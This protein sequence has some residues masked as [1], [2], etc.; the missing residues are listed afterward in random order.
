M[1][2]TRSLLVSLLITVCVS[3]LAFGLAI[4]AS[5]RRQPERAWLIAHLQLGV[6]L[7]AGIL[8]WDFPPALAMIALQVS[9]LAFVALII[10]AACLVLD[11]RQERRQLAIIAAL[12]VSSLA[13]AGFIGI[14]FT[15]R[16]ALLSGALAALQGLGAR[17]L[18]RGSSKETPAQRALGLLAATGAALF[19]LRAG[20]SLTGT[21]PSVLANSATQTL[22]I[23]LGIV[24][25]Q[26][27]GILSALFLRE[28]T[29][30]QL[31][32]DAS[33]DALTHVFNRR[34]FEPL[35]V[36]AISRLQRINSCVGVLMIDIDH[37]KRINDEHGHAAGDHVLTAV[38]ACVGTT[39]RSADI[40]A[41][42]GGEEFAV[43]LA[44]VTDADEALKVAQRLCDAVARLE[45]HTAHETLHCTISVGVAAT[46]T[47]I[48]FDTLVDAADKALYEAKRAGRN[49]VR[50]AQLA[51]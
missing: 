37:F 18:L 16:A 14:A 34:A 42:W 10:D 7:A 23:L 6:S 8:L 51:G 36:G 46:H 28:R 43:L 1:L 21:V 33:H 48:G 31:E 19:L 47:A 38:V 35:A 5:S 40:M 49:C 3:A 17:V 25:I 45:C 41:R 24:L 11:A 20:W 44:D 15:Y 39:L 32:R 9:V 27:T 4:R 22:T 12:G 30:L 29:V 2:D 26:A 50:I 13:L